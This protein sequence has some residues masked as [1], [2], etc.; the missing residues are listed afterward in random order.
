M[1]DFRNNIKGRGA[2]GNTQNR[3]DS[4]HIKMES[5]DGE[6][7]EEG[8]KPLL[9]TQFLRDASKSIATENKSPDIPF[10]YSVNAY[11]GCEHGCAYCYAR[12]THEYLGHSAGLDF[13]S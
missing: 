5:F 1:K 12:P 13:E 6:E 10:R 7:V 8:E 2:V 4:L 11:R 9:R 3:F